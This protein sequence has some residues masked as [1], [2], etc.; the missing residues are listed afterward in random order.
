MRKHRGVFI[1]LLAVQWGA[2]PGAADALKKQ[3]AALVEQGYIEREG[4]MIKSM[5]A[6]SGGEVTVNGK[7]FDHRTLQGGP[8]EPPP[9]ADHPG[10]NTPSPAR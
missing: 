10:M 6:Y 4:A 1:G 2:S 7:P 8:P 5:I 9:R 3:L